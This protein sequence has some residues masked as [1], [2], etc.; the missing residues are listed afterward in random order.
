M[1]QTPFTQLFIEGAFVDSA[2]GG[3]FETHNPAQ[4][5]VLT[6]VSEATAADVDLAVKA[7]QNALVGP[8]SRM[9]LSERAKVIRAVAELLEQRVDELASLESLDTG[10]PIHDARDDVLETAMWFDFYADMGQKVRSSVVPSHK[11]Y[12]NYTVRQPIG[13]VGLIIPWNYPLAL[14][15]LKM[16]A[17]LAMGNAVLLKPAEQTPLSALALANICR[18][19]GI[20]DGVV[21]VLPGYGTSAG[22]A[23]VE[24][25]GVGMVSFTG[26]TEVGREIASL[27]GASLK[28]IT[29]EL[30]GKSPN[31]VFAD[32]DL[33]LASKNSLFTFAVNQGQLCTAGTRLLVERDIHDEFVAE[34]SSQAEAL[35]VGAPDHPDTQLGAIISPAQLSRIEAYVEGGKAAGATLV[36]GGHQVKVSGHEGGWFY[37][38]T[39]F[40]DVESKM[41][42]AQEEIF[43]PVLSVIP[44]DSEDQAIE[45]ANDVIY[46]L[47]ASIWT[48]RVEKA[49]RLAQEIEAGLIYLNTNNITA[50][51]SPYS[52]WKQSG[53]GTEGGFEQA[54]EFTRLKSVWLNLSDDVPHL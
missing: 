45:L 10:K 39:I 23:I 41:R 3:T 25:P 1:T 46:G 11:G 32:A 31:I 6:E 7:A 14:C 19:A 37:S 49:H 26:S 36:T 12:F 8:W 30:G 42:I 2:L 22:R 50:P 4:G 33:E 28:K 43:G 21:N 13:V 40:T 29:L 34:L 48:S 53:T 17:A 18:E 38:P 16:P 47:A 44:F 52:G 51:G 15:G 35:K 54:E 24:H 9:E 5:T 27:A 20:P